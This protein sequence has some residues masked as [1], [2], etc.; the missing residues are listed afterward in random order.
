MKP[1]VKSLALFALLVSVPLLAKAANLFDYWG[2]QPFAYQVVS[3]VPNIATQPTAAVCKV[4]NQVQRAVLIATSPVFYTLHDSSF[5]P[6]ATSA[7][8]ATAA[9]T[10]KVEDV[11]KFRVVA[12]IST[13]SIIMTCLQK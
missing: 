11:S 12:Q 2:G 6:T 3:I 10:I 13:G 1:W 5:N 7:Y 4:G 8:N 9:D